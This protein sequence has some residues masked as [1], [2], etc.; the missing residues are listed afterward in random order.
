MMNDKLMKEMYECQQKMATVIT[1]DGRT[2]HGFVDVFETRYDN[3]GEAS[4]CFAGDG[5]AMLILEESDIKSI[6]SIVADA[7]K[8]MES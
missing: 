3:D 2:L 7:E 8:R 6:K 4:I 5:G 1:S